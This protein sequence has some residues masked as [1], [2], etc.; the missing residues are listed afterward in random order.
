MT[1]STDRASAEASDG[2]G[3]A[4]IVS[5]LSGKSHPVSRTQPFATY[6]SEVAQAARAKY[7]RVFQWCGGYMNPPPHDRSD[8]R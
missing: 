4:T 8:F 3:A 5:T 1:R 7:E 2:V 6:D